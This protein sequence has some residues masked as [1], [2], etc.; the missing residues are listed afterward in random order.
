I[1]ENVLVLCVGKSTYARCFRG[2]TRV[3]L[4]DGSAPTLEEMAPR[5]GEGE[6][7]FGYSIGPLGRPIVTLLEAPRGNRRDS[8]LPDRLDGGGS[9]DA[10]PDHRFLTRDGRMVTAE[11]LRPGDSLMPLY[12]S[13]QRGYEMVYQPSNG[14]LYPTHRLA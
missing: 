7:F 11:S 1:P 10:T 4:V 9:I 3:A 6:L 13:L 12:R 2:D 5:H 14:H 8:L